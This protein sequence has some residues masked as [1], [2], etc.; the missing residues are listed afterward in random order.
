MIDTYTALDGMTWADWVNSEYNS[1]DDYGNSWGA[2]SVDMENN[3]VKYGDRDEI[4]VNED[5]EAV[6]PYDLIIANM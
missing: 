3:V 2:I 6:T 5:W 4:V 1:S